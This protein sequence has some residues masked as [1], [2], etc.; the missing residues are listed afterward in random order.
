MLGKHNHSINDIRADTLS[1]A[2]YKAIAMHLFQHR[3]ILAGHID[4]N[5]YQLGT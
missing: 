5:Q 1:N 2:E 3:A 4:K